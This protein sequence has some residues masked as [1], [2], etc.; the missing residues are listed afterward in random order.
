MKI[1]ILLHNI[2]L[3]LTFRVPTRLMELRYLMKRCKS[4]I[5][6]Q[7]AFAIRYALS[8]NL[9]DQMLYPETMTRDRN[10]R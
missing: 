6:F 9:G 2:K 8:L 1:I 7:L 4:F 3:H 10:A 5:L